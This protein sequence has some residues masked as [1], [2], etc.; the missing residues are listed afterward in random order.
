MPSKA[1]MSTDYKSK[2][3][4]TA[5]KKSTTDVYFCVPQTYCMRETTC[6]PTIHLDEVTP[7]VFN[8]LQ[9]LTQNAK[10]CIVM[11]VSW[12]L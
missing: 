1:S 11:E 12:K 10:V 7:F 5:V 9:I 4:K 2:R 3:G 6:I 8:P